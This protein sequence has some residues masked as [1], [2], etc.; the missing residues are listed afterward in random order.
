MFF[1]DIIDSRRG[2][3]LVEVENFKKR[4]FFLVKK[5]IGTNANFSVLEKFY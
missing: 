4:A 1:R 5:A 2:K 3:I